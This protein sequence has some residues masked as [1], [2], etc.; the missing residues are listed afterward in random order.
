MKSRITAV[1]YQLGALD[2]EE[3]P[4][5]VDVHVHGQISLLASFPA[6]FPAKFA[7]EVVIDPIDQAA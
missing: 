7:C 4:H 2:I 5:P 3:Q 6:S 1:R